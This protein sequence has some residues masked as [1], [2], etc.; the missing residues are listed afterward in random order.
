MTWCASV[1]TDGVHVSY[2]WLLVQALAHTPVP[3][4]DMPK[5]LLWS[6][7]S[8]VCNT[9]SV[10][11]LACQWPYSNMHYISNSLVLQFGVPPELD[12]GEAKIALHHGKMLTNKCRSIRNNT[13]ACFKWRKMWIKWLHT[14]INNKITIYIHK[15]FKIITC[16]ILGL[17]FSNV[18]ACKT[19]SVFNDLVDSCVTGK[20]NRAFCKVGELEDTGIF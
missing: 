5:T 10:S 9:V 2:H 13:W 15:S 17:V 7:G 6:L 16:I 20:R 19:N 8:V 12:S 1:F 18:F 3:N 4:Y 14:E 11:Q